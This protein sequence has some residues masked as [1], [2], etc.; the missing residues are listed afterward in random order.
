MNE[1]MP[2]SVRIGA[3][4]TSRADSDVDA[5]PDDPEMLKCVIRELQFRNSLF[6]ALSE[7]RSYGDLFG[8]E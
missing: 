4:W 1:P 3:T 8:E 2:A 7:C 5:M 6:L